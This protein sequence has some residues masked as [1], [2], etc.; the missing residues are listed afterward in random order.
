MD[1]KNL[2]LNLPIL[3]VINQESLLHSSVSTP[4]SEPEHDIPQETTGRGPAFEM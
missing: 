3:P 1:D 4:M 2:L